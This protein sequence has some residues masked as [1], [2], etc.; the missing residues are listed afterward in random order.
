MG[1][2]ICLPIYR[3]D[4]PRNS[5][6]PFVEI[7]ETMVYLRLS[8]RYALKL[9]ADHDNDNEII[10]YALDALKEIKFKH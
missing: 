8:C 1:K 2:L 3:E 4:V 5:A 6:F 9:Y 7:Y 10:L